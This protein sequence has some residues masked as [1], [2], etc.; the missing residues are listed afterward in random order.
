M[1]SPSGFNFVT[2]FIFDLCELFCTQMLP[3]LFV[4]ARNLITEKC[5]TELSR[6][7]IAN[8]LMLDSKKNS[9]Y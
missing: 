6:W 4:N 9:N 1:W 5:M 8:G 2:A 3:L 7:F